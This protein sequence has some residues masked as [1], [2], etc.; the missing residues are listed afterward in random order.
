MVQ[1]LKDKKFQYFGSARTYYSGLTLGSTI[2][3]SW[4]DFSGTDTGFGAHGITENQRFAIVSSGTSFM[5]WSWNSGASLGGELFGADSVTL[6][7]INRSGVWLRSNA[8]SQK[9]RLWAW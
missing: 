6:D 7:G 5:Q 3:W 1:G 9:V 8:A 2:A 4:I